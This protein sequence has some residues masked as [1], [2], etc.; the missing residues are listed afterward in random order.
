MRAAERETRSG[1]QGDT[2][3][4]CRSS[5][6][7]ATEMG[8]STVCWLQGQGPSYP[9]IWTTFRADFADIFFPNE[10]ATAYSIV[11]PVTLVHG[12][13]DAAAATTA[14]A[15]PATGASAG[16]AGPTETPSAGTRNVLGSGV[17]L[18][19][20]GGLVAGLVGSGF[21]I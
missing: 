7:V 8:F 5:A 3:G 16:G 6:G 17:S 21:V 2:Q 19:F 10:T 11:R 14:A 15:T 18:R 20:F 9:P 1:Y 4:I 12:P 13:A